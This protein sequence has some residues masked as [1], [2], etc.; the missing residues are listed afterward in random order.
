MVPTRGMATVTLRIDDTLDL[1]T[2]VIDATGKIVA[3]GFVDLLTHVDVGG[4]LTEHLAPRRPI[5]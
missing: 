4:R 3:P 5:Q 2:A 1:G